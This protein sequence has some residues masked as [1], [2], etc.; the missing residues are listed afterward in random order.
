[1]KR[2]LVHILPCGLLPLV[3]GGL[4]AFSGITI[5]AEPSKFACVAYVRKDNSISE[6]YRLPYM[7]FD[8]KSLA[9]ASG[10]SYKYAPWNVYT[11]VFWP[12]GGFSAFDGVYRQWQESLNTITYDWAKDQNRRQYRI[13]EAPDSGPCPKP[14]WF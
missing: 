6:G 10:D 11:V 1:M 13:R 9:E 2:F 7:V 4:L 5:A 8:G 14:N 12:N 3:T